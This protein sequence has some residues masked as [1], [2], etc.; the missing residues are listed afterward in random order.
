MKASPVRV[1]TGEWLNSRFDFC[2]L[3]HRDTLDALQADV[4]RVGGLTEARRVTMAAR[5]KG[6]AVVPHCWKSAIG[7]AASAHLVVVSPTCI[8]ME[9]V[10]RELADSSLR[11]DLCSVE[12]SVVGGRIPLPTAPDFVSR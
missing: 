5:D 12:L 1:A 6:L 10:P 7:I 8:Y 11:K 2:E 3:M 4:A 9:F